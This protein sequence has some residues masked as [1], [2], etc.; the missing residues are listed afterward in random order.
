[1]LLGGQVA[2][3]SWKDFEE[4]FRERLKS[5]EETLLTDL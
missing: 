4:G 5:L 1:M 3:G 2:G